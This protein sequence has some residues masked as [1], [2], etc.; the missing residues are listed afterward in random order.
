[1]VP[2]LVAVSFRYVGQAWVVV[3]DLCVCVSLELNTLSNWCIMHQFK[4]RELGSL[5]VVTC[6][7]QQVVKSPAPPFSD[8]SI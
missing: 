1:M 5:W 6:V 7:L 2:N 3:W 4:V 8:Y